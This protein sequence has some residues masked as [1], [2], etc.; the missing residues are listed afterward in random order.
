MRDALGL[1]PKRASK[2]QGNRLDK[3]E[4]SEL[5]KRGSTAEDMG[6]GHAEAAWVHGVGFAR[7]HLAEHSRNVTYPEVP[8][9]VLWVL[10]EI[11]IVACDISEVIGMVFA[12]NMLFQIPVWIGVLLTR[13]GTLVLLALHQ[14]GVRKVKF[15]VFLVLTIAA[16][17]F[18]ELGYAK[19]DAKEVLY[20]FFVPQLKRK[21]CYWSCNFTS[22]C[23]DTV[24]SSTQ[25][26][27]LSRK[28]PRPVQG[29]KM[30]FHF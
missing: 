1:A 25:L 29:I 12:L 27:V 30:K 24:S 23:Y 20:W 3:D 22:G 21:W 28:I 18:G 16:C 9:F 5:V 15:I 17:F 7:K 8:N 26:L 6:A 2:P 11:S 4:L 10:A 19:P 13:F 14:Y